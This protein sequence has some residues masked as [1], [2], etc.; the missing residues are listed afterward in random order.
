MGGILNKLK[1]IESR[2]D[3]INDKVGK[4]TEETLRKFAESISPYLEEIHNKT[5]G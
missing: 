5:Y 2:I 1:E 3:R 4:F